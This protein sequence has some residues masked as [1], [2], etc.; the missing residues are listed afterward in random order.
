KFNLVGAALGLPQDAFWKAVNED[1][2][3]ILFQTALGISTA[4]EYLALIAVLVL[5]APWTRLSLYW[6]TAKRNA[7]VL[8]ISLLVLVLW[9]MLLVVFQVQQFLL[10]R[11]SVIGQTFLEVYSRGLVSV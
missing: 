9:E 6:R 11:P 8:L 5:W 1:G 3:V 7:P 10:P 4:L 2:P